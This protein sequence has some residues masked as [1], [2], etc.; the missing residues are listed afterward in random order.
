MLRLEKMSRKS[1]VALSLFVCYAPFSWILFISENRWEWIKH[2]PILPGGMLGSL[3]R[4]VLARFRVEITSALRAPV[5]L[6]LTV[7]FLGLVIFLM[8]RIPRWRAV[9]A[10]LALGISVILSWG[11]YGMFLA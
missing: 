8:F 10:A 5:A 7:V 11:A 3:L 1:T 9:V 4:F 2:W 6:L